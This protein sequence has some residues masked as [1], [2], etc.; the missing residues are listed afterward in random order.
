M[1]ALQC[2]QDSNQ[3]PLQLVMSGLDVSRLDRFEMKD[4]M[5]QLFRFHDY[6]WFT[7]TIARNAHPCCFCISDNLPGS[8]ISYICLLV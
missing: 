7:R 8:D 4:S 2:L 1:R 5:N 3:Q 6:Q